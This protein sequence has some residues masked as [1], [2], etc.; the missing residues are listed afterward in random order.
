MKRHWRDSA[1]IGTRTDL[2]VCAT[3]AKE[4]EPIKTDVSR[5]RLTL[6]GHEERKR[7]ISRRD[8]IF[9]S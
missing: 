1:K 7:R 5:Y 2:L 8:V 6:T 3:S 4:R 9:G